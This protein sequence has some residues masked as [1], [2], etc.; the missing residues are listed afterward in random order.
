MRV[1]HSVE[2]KIEKTFSVS[3]SLH[4]TNT[5]TPK[6]IQKLFVGGI[7]DTSRGRTRL[8]FQAV[9][10]TLLASSARK[11]TKRW[12]SLTRSFPRRWKLPW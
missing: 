1:C 10:L 7:S 6:R 8:Q 2:T 12:L 5:Q 4:N 11:F 9:L 3:V